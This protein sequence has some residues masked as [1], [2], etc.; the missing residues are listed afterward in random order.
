MTPP[1]PAP[2]RASASRDA[3]H[4]ALKGVFDNAAVPLPAP[5]SS[6]RASSPRAGGALTTKK[7]KKG[8][9]R[10]ALLRDIDRERTAMVETFNKACPFTVFFHRTLNADYNGWL[11][12]CTGRAIGAAVR[13][14]VLQ[15]II[16]HPVGSGQL[17]TQSEFAA[18]CAEIYTEAKQRHDKEVANLRRQERRA[19][20]R[21]ADGADDDEDEDDEEEEEEEE[22]PPKKPNLPNAFKDIVAEYDGAAVEEDAKALGGAH[23]TD[24]ACISLLGIFPQE[25]RPR[26]PNTDDVAVLTN[27]LHALIAWNAKHTEERS[28]EDGT[29]LGTFKGLPRPFIDERFSNLPELPE[30]GVDTP[31]RRAGRGVAAAPR[32]AAK[33]R[34]PSRKPKRKAP[35]SADE[36]TESA[37]EASESDDDD[38]DAASSHHDATASRQHVAP[39]QHAPPA[40]PTTG[41]KAPRTAAAIAHEQARLAA[42]AKKKKVAAAAEEQPDVPARRV[43]MAADREPVVVDDED[44]G[45]PSVPPRHAKILS[46]DGFSRNKRAAPTAPRKARKPKPPTVKATSRAAPRSAAPSSPREGAGVAATVDTTIMAVMRNILS[47]AAPADQKVTLLQLLMES[48]KPHAGAAPMDVVDTVVDAPSPSRHNDAPRSPSPHYLTV[49]GMG[50]RIALKNAR[51]KARERLNVRTDSV[52]EQEEEDEE[53][54][55]DAPARAPTPLTPVT[56]VTPPPPRVDADAAAADDAHPAPMQVEEPPHA[57]APSRAATPQPPPP[58]VASAVASAPPASDPPALTLAAPAPAPPAPAPLTSALAPAPPVASADNVEVAAVV[59]F[60]KTVPPELVAPAP[61][62]HAPA[63]S[64][65]AQCEDPDNVDYGDDAAEE[66]AAARH[67]ASQNNTQ[68]ALPLDDDKEDGETAGPEEQEEDEE[69]PAEQVE[70]PSRK[71]GATKASGKPTKRARRRRR[72]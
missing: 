1:P 20:K 53:D 44:D 69:E 47:G 48:S 70:T 45:E 18:R 38:A 64:L 28:R 54:K 5:P 25:V 26:S 56:P 10:A 15:V 36:E 62:A 39:R 51:V 7:A 3:N 2:A 31:P 33:K 19:A 52:A 67:D 21:L 37:D 27:Y 72:Y 23:E 43:L 49:A 65:A 46:K 13:K 6:P 12:K 66:Q 17:H 22:A 61:A 55:Q 9:A 30:E 35:V 57:A 60:L 71:R 42:L 11:A 68:D 40:H 4:A 50:N 24:T 34:A 59:D 41:M 63:L 29:P 8:G 14:R 58:P 16:E 32:K